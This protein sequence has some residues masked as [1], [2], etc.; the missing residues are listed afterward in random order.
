M[1]TLKHVNFYCLARTQRH[2]V[3]RGGWTGVPDEAT[4]DAQQTADG[5]TEGGCHCSPAV[6]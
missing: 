4:D 1:G 6:G 3:D 2:G 5:W